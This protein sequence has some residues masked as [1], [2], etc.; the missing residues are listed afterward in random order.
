MRV[1]A[2]TL[3]VVLAGCAEEPASEEQADD[4]DD[5]DVRVSD[6]T[7]AILGVIVNDA[8]VPVADVTVALLNTERST[9]TDETGRFVFDDVP[10]GSHF[11]Q[12]SKALHEPVQFSVDVVAGDD[13][14]P[15]TKVQ[16]NRLFQAEPYLSIIQ[17]S[18]FFTCTQAGVPGYLYSSSPCHSVAPGADLCELGGACLD[19]QRDFHADVDAGWQTMVFEMT[20]EPS[21]SGTSERM[22]IVVST[23]KPE[24]SGGH[25]FAEF[26]SSAPLYGR[27]DC[28][29][30]ETCQSHAT[31]SG[32]APTAVPAAGMTDMSYFM[33]VRPSSD[34][35]C[36]LWCV[37]PGVAVDQQFDV[38][39]SQ[40]Y[41]APAPEAWSVINGD[42]RPF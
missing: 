36:V 18:G 24:R 15:I 3:A 22:G 5:V 27:L 19:Q 1:W 29:T 14:P 25:W 41:Y 33:S 28:G 17:N 40:F 10:A 34:A 26:E 30:G 13:E 39:V 35:A 38:W 7:G 42:E 37:P 23:F 6:T 4:F 9:T 21:A 31:A 2:L 16:I 8:I 12:A 32:E 20:W 11:L